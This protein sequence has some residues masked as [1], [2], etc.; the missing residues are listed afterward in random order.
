ML[1]LISSVPF[2]FFWMWQLENLK[3]T[4]V[5]HI[6]CL[7]DSGLLDFQLLTCSFCLQSHS[8]R[9]CRTHS[10]SFFHV[11]QIPMPMSPVQ[12]SSPQCKDS[13]TLSLF[14]IP[15]L[16][17]YLT[18]YNSTYLSSLQH[19]LAV[20]ILIYLVLCLLSICSNWNASLW[21]HGP[22]WSLSLLGSSMKNEAWQISGTQSLF[23][24]KTSL[25]FPLLS[26]Q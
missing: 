14:Q 23:L 13:P 2:H 16:L 4:Y 7:L 19:L 24:D 5:A 11:I 6:M 18:L 20:D 10:S 12:E 3:I 15:G 17:F 8:P 9:F 26:S 25:C 22:C 1:K 21:E